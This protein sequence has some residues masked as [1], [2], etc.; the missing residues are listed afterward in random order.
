M[1][2][3]IITICQDEETTIRWFLDCCIT[4]YNK[5]PRNLKEVVIVDGGSKDNTTE[6]I[7]EYMNSLPLIL[8]EHPFDSWGQQRNKALDLCTGDYIFGPDADM[9]WT[10][11]LADEFDIGHFNGQDFWNLHVYYT[12]QDRH[13]YSVIDSNGASL[14]MWKR[15][16]RFV[17]NFHE[18]L[19]GQPVTPSLCQSVYLFENSLL[20]S[21]KELL[22]RGERLQKYQQP[23]IDAGAGPGSCDRYVTAQNTALKDFKKLPDNIMSIL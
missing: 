4:A 23:L 18:R 10:S 2:W 6:V 5:F 16:P 17:T 14:R 22:N 21:E 9:T 1:T 11:N 7:K 8:I 13:H 20:L 19:E 3:S 15:G 12:A